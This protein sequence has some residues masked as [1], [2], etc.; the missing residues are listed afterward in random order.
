MPKLIAVRP[1]KVA[2]VAT[3]VAASLL[4]IGL[5]ARA[6]AST[7]IVVREGARKLVAIAPDG[8]RPQTLVHLHRGALLGT[9][10]TRDGA[11]IAFV[12]R[13]FHE[14]EGEHVWTDRIWTLRRGAR[15]QVVKTIRSQGGARG[16]R[17]LDSIAISPNG[18]RLLLGRR[19]GDVF[20]IRS[21][22]TALRRARPSFNDFGVGSGRNS[23][24]PEFSPD[25]KRMVGIFYPWDAR[26]SDVGG[27]G[28]VA[29]SGGPVHFLRRGP[30]ANG[31]GHFFGPTFSPNGRLVAFATAGRSGVSITVMNRDGTGAHRLQGSILPGWTISNPS[32]SPSGDSLVFVGDHPGKG[33]TIIGRTPSVIFTIGLDGGRPQVVQAEKARLFDRSPTWVRWPLGRGD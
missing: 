21:D 5:P 20:T 27:I 12:S 17:S 19:R 18:R 7:R 1:F 26:E 14:V 3:L 16:Y 11:L 32:F 33:N 2:V 15:P 22:G 6:G 10:A 13:S 8:G 28:T 4:A 30:F 29:L 9:A 31:V 25:G 24:G 23:T